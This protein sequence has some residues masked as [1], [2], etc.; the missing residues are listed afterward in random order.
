MNFHSIGNWIQILSMFSSHSL[1]TICS[2][3][4][5]SDDR[6]AV[7]E[8]FVLRIATKLAVPET[9]L[10]MVFDLINR[11]SSPG[12]LLFFLNVPHNMFAMW[13]RSSSAS[14]PVRSLSSNQDQTVSLGESPLPTAKV[15]RTLSA[16][17]DHS[18]VLPT[19]D[20]KPFPISRKRKSQSL[21]RQFSTFPANV[22]A[23]SAFLDPRQ[24]VVSDALQDAIETS[25]ETSPRES[26]RER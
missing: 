19:L 6:T 2:R 22:F 18:R 23:S 1:L 24:I 21:Q 8:D 14:C 3:S 20:R 17:I 9:T 26:S 5:G 12:C 25:S 4:L 11:Y 10:G 13:S 16:P 7:L 15:L